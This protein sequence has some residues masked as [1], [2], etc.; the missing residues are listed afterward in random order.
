MPEFDAPADAMEPVPAPANAAMDGVSFGD[1]GLRGQGAAT[2]IVTPA[3]AAGPTARDFFG[4]FARRAA[5]LAAAAASAASPLAVAATSR[6]SVE[7]AA[8][9]AT[10]AAAEVS[11]EP[12]ASSGWPLDAIFGAADDVRDLHAAETLAGIGTFA[13]PDGG[14]GIGELLSPEAA[15]PRRS[16]TRA[17][18]T[19]KF[20]QFFQKPGTAA[21]EPVQADAAPADDDL[22][23]FQDWLKGLKK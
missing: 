18:E 13:G 14:T 3:V 23:Q 19:L 5:V 9:V 10:E 7:R 16:V 1:I 2:P 22:D 6:A 21:N 20:D 15:Q 8:L 4:G 17:S 12:A 11:V